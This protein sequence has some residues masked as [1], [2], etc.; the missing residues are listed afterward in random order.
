MGAT[1]KPR[2]KYRPRPV[3]QNPIKLAIR[4]AGRI[5]ADELDVVMTP[6]HEA[7]TAMREGIGSESHWMVLAGSVELA[8]SI[9][10]QG[11]VHG[12]MGHLTAAEASLAGIKHRAMDR[13]AWKPTPLYWQEIEALDTF[14][15]IHRYQMENLSEGEWRRAHEAAAA[16]VRSAGG[17]VVDIRELRADQAEL[18]LVGGSHG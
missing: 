2:R 7:F 17:Q 6:I 10:R 11:V 16:I 5:P 14:T 3:S 1:A 4:R 18:Q 8:L 13:G 9:E 12:V 15:T